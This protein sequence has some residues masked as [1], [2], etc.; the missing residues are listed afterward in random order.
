MP[1][2]TYLPLLSI[3]AYFYELFE[4][5]NPAIL[6]SVHQKL[7]TH[8]NFR[9]LNSLRKKIMYFSSSK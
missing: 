1:F 9:T 3:K 8:D 6:M 5:Y 4:K 7:F 2:G